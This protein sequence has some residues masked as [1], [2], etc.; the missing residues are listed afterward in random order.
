MVSQ[1]ALF[2]RALE[3][4]QQGHLQK[5][6]RLY[7]KL[8]RR[9]S[10]PADALF[11][12]G[13][14]KMDRGKL[15]R[16][17]ALISR[18]VSAEPKPAFLNSL[19]EVHRRRGH[20]EDARKV[21][22]RALELDPENADAF[23]TLGN[24]H[25][26]A[27]EPQQAALCYKCA[28]AIAPEHPLGLINAGVMA[29]ERGDLPEAV[30]F[31]ERALHVNPS[32]AELRNN[33]GILLDQMDHIPQASEHFKAAL[34][35]APNNS[36]YAQNLIRLLRR[37]RF[38]SFDPWYETFLM[39]C[40][41]RGGLEL[42][43]LSAATTSLLAQK[44]VLKKALERETLDEESVA[45]LAKEPLFIGLLESTLLTD[46]SFESLLQRAAPVCGLES[47][48]LLVAI[49]HQ[50]F[51]NDY[52]L[53]LKPKGALESLD[54]SGTLEGAR[55]EK[56]E[57]A[58]AQRA[59]SAPLHTLD[60]AQDIA[61]LPASTWSVSMAKLI[62]RTLLEPR[63][64]VQLEPEIE[65]L[66]PI[67]GEV[68]QAVRGL[69]EGAPYPRWS[70]LYQVPP[71]PLERS[72]QRVCEGYEPEPSTGQTRILIAGA[73]TGRQ[74]LSVAMAYPDAEVTA[75]DLSR[76][77]LAYAKRMAD[78]L[79][80]SNVRFAQADLL[81]LSTPEPFDYIECVGV[82]HHLE[83]PQAGLLKLV[84]NLKPSGV[85]KLGLYSSRARRA[86]SQA[87]AL[88]TQRGLS[89]EDADV[90]TFR[91]EALQTPEL[92]TLARH[93]DFY[94]LAELKDLVFHPQEHVFE[95]SE[96]A[97]LLSAAGLQFRGFVF[98]ERNVMQHFAREFPEPEARLD[99]GCWHEFEQKNPDVF[100]GMY[101]F[102]CQRM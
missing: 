73:G 20:L 94:S 56:L 30:S 69:Y 18:A 62:R 74:P 12:L 55:L 82:L 5:A 25:R 89:S 15:K 87:R 22:A 71:E 88:V 85:I 97:S 65:T 28:V 80:V 38:H 102:Y 50:A 81:V 37:V 57:L 93:R 17:N 96:I 100:T 75:V 92:Q 98:E 54:L 64:E 33:I 46:L 23:V 78:Q 52:L 34:T 60:C 19:G 39:D 77:S 58:L 44:P 70:T 26:D 27:S 1:S 43:S 2:H 11:L 72:L 101:Q 45:P 68:S 86:I 53:E 48:E 91:R 40:V 8:V 31:Y 66:T 3:H 84:E 32:S 49:A 79:Q 76:R 47:R 99:L 9:K 42:S 4:H 6:E 29:Q 83:V 90:R 63:A 14:I 59:L 95:L 10:P 61:A 21:L 51:H 16:A 24:V 13:T 41:E 36:R 67:E 7:D 35:F